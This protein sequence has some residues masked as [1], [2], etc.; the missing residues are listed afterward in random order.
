MGLQRVRS[1]SDA[2]NLGSKL[3]QRER[4]FSRY[5]D[6]SKSGGAIRFT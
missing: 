1:S 5:D 2:S 4:T 6:L 3:S